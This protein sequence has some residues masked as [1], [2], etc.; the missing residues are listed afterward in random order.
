MGWTDE[1]GVTG[2]VPQAVRQEISAAT[3]GI[4]GFSTIVVGTRMGNVRK[5][6]MNAVSTSRCLRDFNGREYRD[7]T[8]DPLE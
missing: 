6:I 3:A 5:P 8:D 7:A 4:E 1:S 2:P